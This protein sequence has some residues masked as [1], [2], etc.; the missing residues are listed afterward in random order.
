MGITHIVAGTRQSVVNH[1][2]N[3]A[4]MIT[5]TT[6]YVIHSRGSSGY[7]WQV[8][9]KADEKL[10]P[11]AFLKLDAS[12]GLVLS[13]VKKTDKQTLDLRNILTEAFWGAASAC[14]SSNHPEKEGSILLYV[15]MK[16]IDDQSPEGLNIN[17][18]TSRKNLTHEDWL[19]AYLSIE[20]QLELPIHLRQQFKNVMS[21]V[22]V[23]IEF[24]FETQPEDNV[25]SN[26]RASN[27]RKQ[28]QSVSV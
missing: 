8:S 5:R 23:K 27:K 15:A 1:K 12:K 21:E 13:E 3:K 25:A 19:N 18:L 10:T 9:K 22:N 7:I 17:G 24:E 26:K 4:G 6:E 16:A 2:V 28:A 11:L 20:S 14:P